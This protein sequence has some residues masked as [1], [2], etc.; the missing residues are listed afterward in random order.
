MKKE[1]YLNPDVNETITKESETFKEQIEALDEVINK[2]S[3][4]DDD[5]DEQK[6]FEFEFFGGH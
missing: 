2:V 6:I 4:I 3:N 1:I 5:Q